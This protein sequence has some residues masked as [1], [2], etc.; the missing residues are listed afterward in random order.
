MS[1]SLGTR[2]ISYLNAGQLE[3]T[4]SYRFLHSD[5]IYIGTDEQPQVKA[6]G[7][8][9]RLDVNSF[10]LSVRYGITRRFSATVTVPFIHS[11]AS[12]VHPDGTRRSGGPGAQLGDLRVQGSVWL[13]DPPTHPNGNV[14]VSLGVKIPSA[15]EASTGNVFTPSGPVK[16]PIDI[17]QQPGDGGWAILLEGQWFQKVFKNTVAYAAG[18]YLFNPRNTNGVEP[19]QSNATNQFFMSVPDQYSARAG[20]T[21]PVWAGR[22]ISLNLGGRVDGLPVTDVFGSSDGFRRPGY[23]V[24]FEPGVTWSPG[25]NT[26]NFS[27]PIAVSRSIQTSVLDESRNVRTGGGLA[28]FLILAGYS[29]RF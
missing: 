23:V 11:T 19:P 20:L 28:D 17:S 7:R 13:L 5:D 2:D 14:A 27:A 1:P 8:E 22:G 25:K 24:F 26:F 12:V 3:M 18:F 10:D 15:N 9:P 16:K 29:R 4:L 21:L 6:A